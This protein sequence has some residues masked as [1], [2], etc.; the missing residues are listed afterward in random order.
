MW[1][2]GGRYSVFKRNKEK[3]IGI[4]LRTLGNR[5]ASCYYESEKESTHFSRNSSYLKQLL[6]MKILR[7]ITSKR[8]RKQV[9]TFIEGVRVSRPFLFND[10]SKL[11]KRCVELE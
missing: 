3:L 9:A 4:N 7:Q 6:V 10:F 8:G 5:F 2:G 1:E 11:E